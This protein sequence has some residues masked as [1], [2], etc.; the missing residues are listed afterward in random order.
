[1]L[2]LV[3]IGNQIA[4]LRKKKGLTGENL[5]ECLGISPQAVSKWENGKCLPET[6]TLP[7]L[8][9][10]LGCN[11]DALL[12]P[13]TFEDI[14]DMEDLEKLSHVPDNIL[15]T[16]LKGASPQLREYLLT[17]LSVGRS[18]AIR[19]EID[20]QGP[21]RIS[22]VEAAQKEVLAKII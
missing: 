9:K 17:R 16:A 10:I 13:T 19:K 15:A 1:M 5:A 4:F 6:A 20:L 8:S 3:K 21:V 2:D 18:E 22:Q 12:A 11:I 14:L 7:E